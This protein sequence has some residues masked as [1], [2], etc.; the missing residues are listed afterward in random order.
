MLKGE[1]MHI[2]GYVFGRIIIDGKA[3]TTD[4]IIY[5]DRVNSSWWR[6]EGHSLYK[7]DLPG[8]AEA[9]PDVLVIGTGNMGVMQVPESTIK[10][11][12]E[13]GIEVHV[14]KTGKAVEMF[15]EL[16]AGKKVIAAFHLTC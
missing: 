4:V 6:T 3:Y 10:Y 8:I 11:F 13:Q 15:N 5:P 9:K 14:A 1:K 16:S 2:D 12:E 7:K